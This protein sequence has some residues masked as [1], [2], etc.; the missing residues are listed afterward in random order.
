LGFLHY[1]FNDN[2][3]RFRNFMGYD[4]R[5]LEEQGSE[6][7]HGRAIWGLGMAVALSKSESLTGA[8]MTI[9]ERALGAMVHFQSP[10]AWAFGLVGIHAYLKQFSGDTEVRRV[11]EAL[12]NALFD[13]FQANATDDWP[14]V[15]DSVNYAN[16][17]IPQALLLSGRWLHRKDMI[18]AGLRS[19]DWLVLIQTDPKGHFVPIGS[20]G[21]FTRDGQR[22]RF[23]QQPLEAQNMIEGCIEAYRITGERKWIEAA[24]RCFDWFLGRNDLNVPLYDYRTG[25]CCDGL[26]ADGANQNQ[27]AESTL[28][29]LLSLLSLH[30]LMASEV[31]T[32]EHV[33]T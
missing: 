27:G 21:W 8:T 6:D 15:E 2:N 17:R 20:H 32:Q 3:G 10:R 26:T 33:I 31:S 30:S 5:W 29:W 16:A 24:R 11:R 25:G 23:D 7:C 12:A 14:W 13:Q 19:L 4:R 28:A 1:A 9:F 22:A 18:N